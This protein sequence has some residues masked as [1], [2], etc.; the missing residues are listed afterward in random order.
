MP[1][2]CQ[3]D[4][5]VL[6]AMGSVSGSGVMM[7]GLCWKRFGSADSGPCFSEPAMGWEPRNFVGSERYLWA[8]VTTEAL[9]E[10]TSVMKRSGR[11]KGAMS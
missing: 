1:M 10:P 3:R 7:Q 5:T 8:E 6:M 2:D 11:C 9:V 4:L